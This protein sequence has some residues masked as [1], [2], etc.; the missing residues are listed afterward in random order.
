MSPHQERKGI[1]LALST[2]LH[3]LCVRVILLAELGDDDWESFL[4]TVCHVYGF[5]VPQNMCLP[6]VERDRFFMN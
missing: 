2:G 1:L 4:W 6:L 3:E 5:L